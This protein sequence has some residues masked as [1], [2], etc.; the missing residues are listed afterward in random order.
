M[1]ALPKTAPRTMR[2]G[3][4]E[5]SAPGCWDRPQRSSPES[6]P[7]N[8]AFVP[9]NEP[10]LRPNDGAEHEETEEAE[11]DDEGEDAAGIELGRCDADQ[12]AEALAATQEL[13]RDGA[14]HDA[15]GGDLE[16]GEEVRQPHRQLHLDEGLQAA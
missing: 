11:I 2:V 14:R 13:A 5:L 15:D 16:A 8:G 12:F 9:K 6:V 4:G 7:A 3:R 1:S 10:A